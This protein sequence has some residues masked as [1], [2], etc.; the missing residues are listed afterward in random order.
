MSHVTTLQQLVVVPIGSAMLWGQEGT[1]DV[2]VQCSWNVQKLGCKRFGG[3]GQWTRM[4]SCWIQP[5]FDS[6]EIIA[7]KQWRKAQEMLDNPGLHEELRGGLSTAH[8]WLEM[9]NQRVPLKNGHV[10]RTCPP[11]LGYAFA[12]GTSDGPGF[13]TFRWANGLKNYTL[14]I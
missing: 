2:T 5:E 13:V 6:T 8:Q 1:R 12:A 10:G 3:S 9:S 4:K 14:I 7:G 11:A